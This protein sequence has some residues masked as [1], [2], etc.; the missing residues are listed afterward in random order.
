MPT[1]VEQVQVHPSLESAG[2]TVPVRSDG[3]GQTVTV[4]RGLLRDPGPGLEASGTKIQLITEGAIP[5][6]SRDF[7]FLSDSV[8]I[9]KL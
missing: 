3:H 2:V 7:P 4:G 1:S 9:F 8:D 6:K 5:Q